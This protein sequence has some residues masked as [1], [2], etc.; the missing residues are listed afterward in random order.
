MGIKMRKQKFSG[1]E[2]VTNCVQVHAPNSFWEGVSGLADRGG[3][4][5]S[6]QLINF[7][8]EGG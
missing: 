8:R 2:Y 5:S 3:G 1:C 7:E 6:V 4:D